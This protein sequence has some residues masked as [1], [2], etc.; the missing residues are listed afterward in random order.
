MLCYC[1]DQAEISGRKTWQGMSRNEAGCWP[2][3][4]SATL[5]RETCVALRCPRSRLP[6]LLTRDRPRRPLAG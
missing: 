5:H 4:S 3:M 2:S 1:T 6:Y